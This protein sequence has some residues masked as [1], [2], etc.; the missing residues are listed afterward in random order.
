MHGQVVIRDVFC[1]SALNRTGIPGYDYCMNPYGGCTHAC[2]YC[3]APYICRFT[4]HAE[5][6]GEF[7]DV[8]VNFP[9]VLEKQL[10]RRRTQPKG[11]ILLGTV[12]DAYQ[13]AEARYEI[14]RSGWIASILMQ[15]LSIA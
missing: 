1:K 14:T 10:S 12:L 3:Y 13:P 7:L 8:K 9:A 5:K 15:R 11:R 4:G 2:R 6:W